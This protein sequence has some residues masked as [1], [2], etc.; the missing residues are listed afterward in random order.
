[1]AD[2]TPP[3]PAASPTA[4]KGTPTHGDG[5]DTDAVVF[6][7]AHLHGSRR[8][9]SYGGEGAQMA[10]TPRAQAALDALVAAGYAV[11]T[12]DPHDARPGRLHWQG[13]DRDPSLGA[14]ARARGID[15]FD[16]DHAWPAFVAKA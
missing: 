6:G 14:I 13:V 15:P 2:T 7:L 11:P 10:I 5:L 4:P 9:L 8:T 12:A 16:P 3:S 1:M